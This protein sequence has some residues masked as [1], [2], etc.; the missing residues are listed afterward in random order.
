M[1]SRVDV[2]VK[3]D[4]TE[5]FGVVHSDD[6]QTGMD[7]LADAALGMQKRLCPVDT[8][9]LVRHLD[10]RKRADGG[11]DIGVFEKPPLISA[12]YAQYVEEGH[13]TEAGTMVPAQPFIRP[14]LDAVRARLARG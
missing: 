12:Y 6:V 3:L 1:A 10:V 5:I 9:N 8:G 4:D 7:D 13:E 2:T 11:R 14:S